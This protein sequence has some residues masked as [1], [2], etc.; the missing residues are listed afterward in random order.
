MASWI[1]SLFGGNEEVNPLTELPE[2]LKKIFE[3][4]KR[5]R[6]ALRDLLRRSEKAQEVLQDVSGP[7]ATVQA[8]A[9]SMTL[10]MKE[11][12]ARVDAFTDVSE[13]VDSVEHRARELTESQSKATTTLDDAAK[14]VSDLK[15][16]V[17]DIRSMV[18]EIVTARDD[19]TEM[20][21]PYGTVATLLKRVNVLREELQQMQDRGSALKETSAQL[22]VV[23]GQIAEIGASQKEL[24]DTV[25]RGT[26]SANRL[27]AQV[28]ELQ[29]QVEKVSDARAVMAELLGPNGGLSVVQKEFG[30]LKEELAR[31]EG[32]TVDLGQLEARVEEIG[33]KADSVAANQQTALNAVQSTSGDIKE[34]DSKVADIRKGVESVSV[35]RQEIADL[36]GP[37]GALSKLRT[38]LEEAR[39]K[40][41][42]YSEDVARI[43]EDQSDARSTQEGLLAQYAELRSK[44][45]ALD[46]GVEQ[47][48]NR[49]ASV[50]NTMRDLTKAEELASR[51]ER[52]LNALRGLSDHVSQKTA[53]LERQREAINRTE[54]QARA[55]TDLHWELEAKLKEAKGQ[56]KEVKKV[57]ASVESLRALHAKVAEQSEELRTGQARIRAEDKE[58]RS[59][60]ASLQEEV[61]TSTQSYELGQAN[62]EA[63]DHRIADLRVGVTDFENRFRA[64]DEASQRVSEATRRGDVLAGRLTSL[65]SHLDQ[66]SEQVELVAGM[67]EGMTRAEAAAVEVASR[68]ERIEARESEVQDA[69][70]DL[71][72]L[73]GSHEEV[74]NALERLRATRAEIERMQAGHLET[75]AWL[76]TA[77]ES[78]GELR[79][80]MAQLDDLTANVDHMRRNA[81]CVIAAAYQLEQR[82]PSLTELDNR[83]SELREIGMQLDERTSNLLASL[84]DADRRFEAV[85][86]QAEAAD[87]V[88]SVIEE[89]TASVRKAENRM[90]DLGEGVDEAV[91]RAE[92][93]KSLSE[94]VDRVAAD[95]AQRQRA[96][97]KAM[98]QLD[99]VATL[100]QEAGNVVQSLEDQLRSV[101]EH[102]AQA[103]EQSAKMGSRAEMLEA[104]AGSLRFAEKRITQFEEKLV[105]LD[106][107]EKELG[108]SIE[109]LIARQ[110]S[111]DQVRDEVQDLFTRAESTLKDVRAISAASDEVQTASENLVV[112]RAKAEEMTEVLETIDQRQEQIEAAEARLARADG[113]LMDIRAGLESLRSQKAVVD[114]VIS[115]SGQLTYE[116]KEAERLLIQ[117]RQ[118]RDLTQGIRDA[119]QEMRD[120]DSDT[121]SLPKGTDGPL[122]PGPRS[123]RH[124]WRPTR[125]R[126]DSRTR[127]GVVGPVRAPGSGRS[128]RV[129][130]RPSGSAAR[131]TFLPPPRRASAP[132]SPRQRRLLRSPCGRL[133]R[134][135]PFV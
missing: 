111:I 103:E 135:P 96:L 43:K 69:V 30:K 38:Q 110:G 94:R 59:A 97:D 128:S 101:T 90:Q 63:I 91:E 130:W 66:L 76:A 81:D 121:S 108:R 34:L 93:I 83:M 87:E 73:R 46:K 106:K 36:S 51:T 54:G 40:S 32:R 75:A 7:L 80:R 74:L 1:K 48:S 4:A 131:P 107:V 105:E 28:T 23:D 15:M 65:S 72:T 42:D 123:G 22:D 61:R 95:I 118:E 133:R 39:A 9:E 47:A 114:Q 115:T 31:I 68:L 3:Q 11:L 60:L 92:Y 10:Q 27:E 8:S 79:Q 112:L 19:L 5:D 55:L 78:I 82:E 99:R 21:G 24:T 102:L 49:V 16:Q 117:L 120:E 12:Q 119:L 104:R 124:G 67:R 88:R 37:S 6:K 2:D 98:E 132:T 13:K 134:G 113:L 116:A 53:A 71:T 29:V 35:A 50:E 20:A 126:A 109:T 127:A 129:P 77:Q 58:L 70:R 125:S 62:L 84:S 25:L 17:R 26:N 122:A 64:L 89:V 44:M 86:V 14:R 52:Q 85:A 33:R 57:N 45:D 100:R 56:V 41:L 18:D